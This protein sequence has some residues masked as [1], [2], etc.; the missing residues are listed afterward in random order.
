MVT[1]RLSLAG[2]YQGMKSVS[3]SL[4]VDGVPHAID[5]KIV[6]FDKEGPK[7]ELFNSDGIVDGWDLPSIP[8]NPALDSLPPLPRE[9]FAQVRRF[10]AEPTGRLGG[11]PSGEHSGP[12]GG[13]FGGPFMGQPS[14][15]PLPSREDY[16]G[17]AGPF[18]GQPSG[19]QWGAFM[20]QPSGEHSGQFIGQ[21]SG[22]H[23]NPANRPYR[24]HV[25]G[26]PPPSG[27]PPREVTVETRENLRFRGCEELR[28]EIQIKDNVIGIPAGMNTSYMSKVVVYNHSNRKISLDLSPLRS[29][30]S[31]Q[32]NNIVIEP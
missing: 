1:R 27:E 18:I 15:E 10:P 12:F 22:E 30:F 25:G 19:E 31:C 8:A 9:Q 11:Q 23:W 2:R 21:P 14:G 7:I 28:S 29:P 24:E 16:Y 13:P 26:V 32:Y 3:L 17:G 4:V 20:G 6:C 5:V